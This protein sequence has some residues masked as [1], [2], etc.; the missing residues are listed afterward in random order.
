MMLL[1]LRLA[2]G[3]AFVHR[4]QQR[5]REKVWSTCFLNKINEFCY[6]IA[7]WGNIQ[8]GKI[9]MNKGWVGFRSSMAV[10]LCFGGLLGCAQPTFYSPAV[11]GYGY[12]EQKIAPDRYQVVFAGNHKTRRETA[13]QYVLFRAAQL[14]HDAGYDVVAVNDQS[15]RIERYGDLRSRPTERVDLGREDG[16]GPGSLG[17]NR[18]GD[19]QVRSTV[20]RYQAILD[21]SFY[22]DEKSVPA[23][24]N[25]VYRTDEVLAEL[26]GAI[27]FEG[28][29]TDGKYVSDLFSLTGRQ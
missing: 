29:P 21:V 18:G 17:R 22:D 23:A 9:V 1:A 2:R 12:A 11:N 20:E 6:P 4:C 27:E 5:Q 3:C 15:Q 24:A 13:H 28:E 25:D 8:S 19:D 14:A 7:P 10:A 26:A 16:G